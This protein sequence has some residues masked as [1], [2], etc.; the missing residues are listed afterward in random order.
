MKNCK[1]ILINLTVLAGILLLGFSLASS[2][3]I[4]LKSAPHDGTFKK[5]QP[6]STILVDFLTEGFETW[7]PPGWSSLITNPG[8]TMVPGKFQ[9]LRR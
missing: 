4:T 1:N 3:D 6:Q 5:P 7:F 8:Y 2:E 9:S